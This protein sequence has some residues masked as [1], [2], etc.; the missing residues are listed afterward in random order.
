MIHRIGY[1]SGLQYHPIYLNWKSFNMVSA[2]CMTKWLS[3]TN[4]DMFSM[5]TSWDSLKNKIFII[6][7]LDCMKVIQPIFLDWKRFYM[8]SAIKWLSLTN[9]G[10]FVI[11]ATLWNAWRINFWLYSSYELSKWFAISRICWKHFGNTKENIWPWIQA[12]SKLLKFVEHFLQFF[13]M[14][15]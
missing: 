4:F 14:H 5:V 6:D 2:L 3:L 10:M 8:V 1:K 7:R 15:T 9:F 13:M 12:F 11:M